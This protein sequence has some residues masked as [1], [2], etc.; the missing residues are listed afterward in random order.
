[1]ATPSI[2]IR[3]EV[4]EFLNVVKTYVDFTSEIKTHHLSEAGLLRKDFNKV[5]FYHNTDSDSAQ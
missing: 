4:V 1:M 3:V 5:Y 2:Q